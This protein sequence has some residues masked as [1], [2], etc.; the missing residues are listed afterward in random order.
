[1]SNDRPYQPIS[2]DFHDHLEATATRR[3]TARI[4]YTDVDGRLREVDASIDD[5]ASRDGEEFMRLQSG[6]S[7]RLDRIVSV[8]G[9]RLSDHADAGPDR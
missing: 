9:V 1:M 6:L 7:I 3:S 4:V 8:D 2:C 5:L